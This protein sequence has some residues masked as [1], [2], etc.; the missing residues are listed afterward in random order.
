MTFRHGRATAVGVLALAGLAASVPAAADPVVGRYEDSTNISCTTVLG[1]GTFIDF[2]LNHAEGTE[3]T[4]L[5]AVVEIRSSD[6]VLL[7]SGSTDQLVLQDG[8][9]SATVDLV[10]E[11]GE[12]AGSA[13]FEGSY[14][15]AADPIVLR[16]R[17]L[18]IEGNLQQVQTTT[19]TPLAVRWQTVAIGET[20]LVRGGQTLIDP[21]CDGYR[22]IR[23]DRTTA[24]HR[25]SVS[26]E[27]YVL[28]AECSAPPLD[29]FLVLDSDAGLSLGFVAQGF[30][31]ETN[32][33]VQNA[34]PQPV[35][36]SGPGDEFVRT[37]ISATLQA[38]GTPS[39]KTTVERGRTVRT[40]ARPLSLAFTLGLPDGTTM[41][42][43]CRVDQVSVHVTTE[44]QQ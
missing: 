33:D 3:G 6:D 36:W 44:P 25:I 12:P 17:P 4:N 16:G 21:N 41:T 39:T 31:G 9:A 19:F 23:D 5:F 13:V 27:G 26:R 42:G 22:L 18:Q 28:P 8:S 10:D 15:A 20:V 2:G 7:G 38:A 24:P 1:D 29:E 34:G 35:G 43:A 32:L 37:T 30:F 14:E 40:T 11:S